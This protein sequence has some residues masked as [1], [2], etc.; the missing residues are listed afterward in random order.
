[1]MRRCIEALY[2]P[3]RRYIGFGDGVTSEMHQ[4]YGSWWAE[5]VKNLRELMSSDWGPDHVLSKMW[6]NYFDSLLSHEL[7]ETEE[8]F[9]S[10]LRFDIQ[11]CNLW[12]SGSTITSLAPDILTGL[13][14][15]HH[16]AL[17]DRLRA[18][19]APSYFPRPYARPPFQ[20]SRAPATGPS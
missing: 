8:D 12:W 19:A 18:I 20:P 16:K 15:I 9:T 2:M 7:Y 5:A 13:T 6:S 14:K 11:T 1:M 4:I 10:I 17:E 3:T